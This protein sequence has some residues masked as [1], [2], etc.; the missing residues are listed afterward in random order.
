MNSQTAKSHQNSIAHCPATGTSE[1]ASQRDSGYG[2][3]WIR[4]VSGGASGRTRTAL[5]II[6]TY[7]ASAKSA[8]P[9]LSTGD[10]REVQAIAFYS[11]ESS[12]RHCC[13]WGGRKCPFGCAES[14]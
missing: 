4:S 14:D 11:L 13:H 3:T 9:T 7:G 1:F 8:F 10:P 6:E 5:S 2:S 12:R